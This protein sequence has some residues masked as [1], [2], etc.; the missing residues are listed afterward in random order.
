MIVE[1]NNYFGELA[2]GERFFLAN[3]AD[4]RLLMKT[5]VIFYEKEDC[6]LNAVSLNDG[7]FH[8]YDDDVEV[9]PVSAKRVSK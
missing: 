1:T 2:Q 5:E 7:V 4:K 3:K 8:S 6:Y 9:I